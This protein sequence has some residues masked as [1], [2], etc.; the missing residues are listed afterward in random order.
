[1]TACGDPLKMKIGS[2]EREREPRR[3]YADV[4]LSLDLSFG[5]SR[6]PRDC[7]ECLSISTNVAMILSLH[8]S[9]LLFGCNPN[10][11]LIT[12]EKIDQ[13]DNRQLPSQ[14]KIKQ[15]TKKSKGLPM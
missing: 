6:R 15:Q 11:L 4:K 1:M 13:L 9:Y 10:Q 3:S 14:H 5:L 7:N 2:G 12:Q 8:V